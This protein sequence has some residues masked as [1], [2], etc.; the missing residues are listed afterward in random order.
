MSEKQSQEVI[1]TTYYTPHCVTLVFKENG[2][3]AFELSLSIREAKR[4]A[5][6]LRLDAEKAEFQDKLTN[7]NED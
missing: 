2:K 5:E 6:Q 3:K 7:E 4:F 1:V